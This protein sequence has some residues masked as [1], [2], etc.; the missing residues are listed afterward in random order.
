[1]PIK[2]LLNGMLLFETTSFKFTRKK[3]ARGFV[4]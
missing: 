4:E 1:M 2:N 3:N